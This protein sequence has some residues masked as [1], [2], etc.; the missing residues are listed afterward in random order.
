MTVCHIPARLRY[1]KAWAEQ[2]YELRKEDWYR[3]QRRNF[4]DKERR[5][6]CRYAKEWRDLAFDLLM[7]SAS[8]GVVA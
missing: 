2:E 6:R 7:A 5:D 3:E 4:F 8:Y 1:S